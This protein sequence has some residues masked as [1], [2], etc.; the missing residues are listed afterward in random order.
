[1]KPFST[2]IREL[3]EWIQS[4]RSH[5]STLQNEA[6]SLLGRLAQFAA[7][8][9]K[10]DALAHAPLT[11]GLYSAS[12]AGKA[13]VLRTLLAQG[14]DHITVQLGDKSL[15]YLR[16]INPP[17]ALT[18]LAVRLTS[19][20]PPEVENY[21]LLLN[22]LSEDQLAIPL[23][24]RYHARGEPRLLSES[25]M[26]KKLSTL[27]KQ[28]QKQLV[29]GMSREQFAAIAHSYQQQVHSE[30]YPDDDLLWQMTELA[31]WLTV[32]DRATLLALFWGEEPTLTQ[33]WLEQAQVLHLLGGAEQVLAPASLVVDKF[34]LPAEGFLVLPEQAHTAE[35]IDVIVCTLRDRKP[36][37]HVN[38]AQQSL[39]RVCAEVVLTLSAT[40]NLG[41]IDIVDIPRHEQ[42]RYTATLQPDILMVCNAVESSLE[43]VPVA[44][45]LNRWLEQTQSEADEG[46]PRLIWAITPYD[47]R[48]TQKTILDNDVQHLLTQA[49]KKWGTLQALESHSMH[50]LQEWLASAIS[51]TNRRVRHQALQHRLS[52]D[53][54]AQFAH[55]RTASGQAQTP[56][57]E[58]ETLI[59]TLQSQAAR[60]GEL[61]DQLTLPREMIRQCWQRCEQQHRPLPM[62]SAFE[63]DL[64]AVEKDPVPTA[65][66]ENNF[67]R[68][69]HKRW[70]NYLRQL[71]YRKHIAAQLGLSAQEIQALCELLIDTSYRIDLGSELEKALQH[72][73]SHSSLMPTCAGNI[74]NDFIGWLGY[75]NVPQENRPPSRINKGQAIFSPPHQANAAMR[76][77]QLGE[78]QAQGN[79]SY[80][81]D[82]LVALYVRAIEN[83]QDS[84]WDIGEDQRGNLVRILKQ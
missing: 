4:N 52:Q 50:R 45:T 27:Q 16:H 62:L 7:R 23:V 59:R 41:E 69:L 15:N 53:V 30:H 5:S 11:L 13:H 18:A 72:R 8:Q 35:N 81:Y 38:V 14:L 66:D 79:A 6:N 36:L 56:A 51:P 46:L 3:E 21:P 71:G 17:T 68:Q 49:G 39:R 26:Y 48:F 65:I 83:S 2:T 31:P 32:N 82:W 1:M 24:Q 40:T 77:T 37:T 76:L 33:D 29:P 60:Q 44:S 73:D 74:L 9:Q 78:R 19:T 47:P 61:L 70:I 25:A 64:F 12:V 34:L 58:A 80:L 28:R 54:R 67:S 43:V 55:I 84:Q 22:M 20:L 10:I 42:D 57:Q 63:I 75:Q